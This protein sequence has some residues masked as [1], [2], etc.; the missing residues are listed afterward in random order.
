MQNFFREALES[1]GILYWNHWN[2]RR[3]FHEL[4][5][6]DS[7]HLAS[8]R[9]YAHCISLHN[10]MWNLFQLAHCV[11]SCVDKN[12]ASVITDSCAFTAPHATPC[13]AMQRHATPCNAIQCTTH[14]R[15]DSTQ[16]PGQCGLASIKSTEALTCADVADIC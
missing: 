10:C 8:V 15:P 5:S 6:C 2:I 12:N 3:E 13:N 16:E 9:N 7:I 11:S 14:V 4:R 1:C